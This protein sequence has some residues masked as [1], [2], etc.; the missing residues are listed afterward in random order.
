MTEIY[1]EMP[2]VVIAAKWW[3][4][5]LKNQGAKFDVGDDRL[6]MNIELFREKININ[7]KIDKEL[8]TIMINNF[9]IFLRK[10]IVEYMKKNEWP[11][12]VCT[13]EVDY[14]P[15]EMISKALRD[16]GFPKNLYLLPVKS[17]VRL[18]RSGL[19]TAKLGYGAEDKTIY[20]TEEAKRYLAQKAIEQIKKGVFHLGEARRC[21]IR[22]ISNDVTD[23]LLRIDDNL[24]IIVAY[25][26]KLEESE[27]IE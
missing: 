5:Q 22:H 19:V 20:I 24:E 3:S 1:E 21:Y 10:H 7:K 27:N 25:I 13:L 26:K 17:R 14:S 23:N 16:A 2:E 15:D 18:E 4:D 8:L 11:R 9:E 12:S 6:N